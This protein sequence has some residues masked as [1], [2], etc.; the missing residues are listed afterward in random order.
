MS[1]FQFLF[2]SLLFQLESLHWLCFLI[3]FQIKIDCYIGLNFVI[4]NDLWCYI[5]IIGKHFIKIYYIFIIGKQIYIYLCVCICMRFPK[6]VKEL[7]I[8]LKL[9][10]HPFLPL[11]FP[12]KNG[13]PVL[14]EIISNISKIIQNNSSISVYP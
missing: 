12:K 10:L 8:L 13:H 6:Y 2:F 14:V 9:H 3:L 1:S 11:F 4:S 5:F 7:Y